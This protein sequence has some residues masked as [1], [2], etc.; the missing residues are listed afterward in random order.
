MCVLKMFCDCC[1]LVMCAFIALS[2][3]HWFTDVVVGDFTPH[4]F[5][6]TF[7]AGV[8]LICTYMYIYLRA[9]PYPLGFRLSYRSVSI[10]NLC[11]SLSIY[12]YVYVYVSLASFLFV[13][14]AHRISLPACPSVSVSLFIYYLRCLFGSYFSS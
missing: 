7:L 6:F 12:M 1:V 4:I 14:A 13:A 11:I 9:H 8:G 5:F 10:S 3:I 2:S